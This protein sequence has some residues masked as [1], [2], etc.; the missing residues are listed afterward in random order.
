MNSISGLITAALLPIFAFTCLAKTGVD[1]AFLANETN[2]ANWAGFGRTYSEQRFSPLAQINAQN[3]R[4][5]GIDW[6]LD[7]PKDRSLTGT[8]LVID[9]V[10]YFNGSY[11]IVRAVNAATG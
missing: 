7:L 2:E 3:V 6:F 11:N 5:I 1:D 4:E 9:G 8:P 10:M